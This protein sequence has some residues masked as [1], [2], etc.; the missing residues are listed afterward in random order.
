[1][2]DDVCMELVCCHEQLDLC[3]NSTGFSTFSAAAQPFSLLG[4]LRGWAPIQRYQVKCSTQKI[5]W[6]IHDFSRIFTRNTL[7][8]KPYQ[9][10]GHA[11]AT[12]G[13]I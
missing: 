5:L 6:I 13:V 8:M 2:Y 10:S 3:L 1:M 7:D 9:P 4:R 11:W 12:K